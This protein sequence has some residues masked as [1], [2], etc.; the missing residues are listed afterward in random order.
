MPVYVIGPVHTGRSVGGPTGASGLI[1]AGSHTVVS[2][3]PH[4][5]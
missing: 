3:G 1:S 4:T 5:L 2:T